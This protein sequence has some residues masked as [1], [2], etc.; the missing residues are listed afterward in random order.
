MVSQQSNANDKLRNP[1]EYLFER[2]N[3]YGCGSNASKLFLIG[4][5]DYTGKTGNFK[6]VRCDNCHLVYQ[7]PRISINQIKYFYDEEYIA[8]RKTKDWGVLTPIYNW[9]MSKLDRR[10]HKIVKQYTT[11]NNKIR[12][13]DIGCAVGTFLTFLRK[14]Y[15]CQVSGVDFADLANYPGMEEIN[16]Y[17]GLFYDQDFT[18]K[19]FDLITMWHFLE[20]DYDPIRTLKLSESLLTKEG[21]LIIEVPR[22]DSLTFKL[23]RNRWPGIQAPQH[24]ILFDESHIRAFVEKANLQIIDHLAY[25][26]F[27]AYFYIYTGFAFTRL[28]GEGLNIRKEMLP[29]FAGQL[30]F[31]PFL[32]FENYLNLSMQ[33]IICRKKG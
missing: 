7:D 18:G 32:L 30:L 17:N 21:R 16:F 24:T 9:T 20:H 29:Y 25:G 8:H 2:V 11:L 1:A 31:A 13:L 28:K 15:K 27:P 12:V 5:D 26:A 19:E 10:K 22:L 3:C 33:T 23:F 14:Q 6:Y 4:Q